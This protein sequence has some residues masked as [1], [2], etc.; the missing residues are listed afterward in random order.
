VKAEKG[1]KKKDDEDDDEDSGVSK[2]YLSEV[3]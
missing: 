3:I 2:I 1:K